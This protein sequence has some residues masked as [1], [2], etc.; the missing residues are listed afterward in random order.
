MLIC[1]IKDSIK[2]S[3]EQLEM[4][5]PGEE[6]YLA[7]DHTDP[8]LEN[9]DMFVQTNLLKRKFIWRNIH[10]GYQYILDS[11]KPKVVIESPM[12]RKVYHNWNRGE[13]PKHLRFGWNSYLYNKGDY[14]NQNSPPDRW[15]KLQKN[16]DIKNEDWK[17]EGDYILFLCQKSGDS[18][19]NHLYQDYE[20]YWEWIDEKVQEIRQYTDRTIVLRPHL[21]QQG[22]SIPNLKEISSRYKN[23]R[24]SKNI[25]SGLTH[26]GGESLQEDL[27]NAH[28]AVT[29]NSLAGVDAVLAGV[30]LIA[31]D[32]GCMATP[33][34]HLNLDQVESLDRNID[35][36]QWLYDS[37]YTQWD[38]DEFASGE[39]WNHLKPNYE[40]WK[41][42]ASQQ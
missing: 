36:T 33:V 18:S 6:I 1:G 32:Q 30:P 35:K 15:K 39:A 38:G 22:R 17:K 40:K 9:A 23:V 31:L 13:S 27:K 20:T 29:F 3:K 10:H 14:N 37:A 42:L 11:K 2:K 16:F 12:F 25:P 41:L 28:C 19:M 4:M 5:F 34:A 7:E 8:N 21:L 26:Y 24:L